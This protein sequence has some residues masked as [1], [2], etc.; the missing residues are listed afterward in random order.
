MTEEI[1]KDSVL[2]LAQYPTNNALLI[3]SRLS[4]DAEIF[5]ND[6]R[7]S[8]QIGAKRAKT[9]MQ[10]VNI[11]T[12]L[13]YHHW[14]LGTCDATLSVGSGSKRNTYIQDDFSEREEALL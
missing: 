10:C 4:S 14:W 6:H 3:N 9:C 7:L 12:K 2:H 11:P 8:I 13:P 5:A 1:L